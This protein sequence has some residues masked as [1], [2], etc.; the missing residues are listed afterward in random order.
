[1]LLKPPVPSSGRGALL[2]FGWVPMF[3]SARRESE[4]YWGLE[5]ERTELLCR[6]SCFCSREG[7]VTQTMTWTN[8]KKIV[9]SE[10]HQRKEYVL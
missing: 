7:I 5:L 2:I 10:R 4:A 1:M 3:P 8:C 6:R 9:L